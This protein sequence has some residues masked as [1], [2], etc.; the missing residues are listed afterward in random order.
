MQNRFRIAALATLCVVNAPAWS[1]APAT[2]TQR[3]EIIGPSPVARAA[4]ALALAEADGDRRFQLSNGR[5]A[6]VNMVGESLQLVYRQRHSLLKPDGQGAFVS[7][8]GRISVRLTLDQAGE[9]SE[10]AIAAPSSWF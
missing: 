10:V 6:V 8:D 9:A 7:S 2:D 3:V 1:T 5:Q 4:L